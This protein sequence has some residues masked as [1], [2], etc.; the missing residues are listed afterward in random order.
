MLTNNLRLL[1]ANNNIDTISELVE[2]SGLSR[3]AVNKI[4]RDENI[5]NMSLAT[6]I[7]LCDA[8]KCSL[9]MLVEYVPEGVAVNEQQGQYKVDISDEI[10]NLR[11]QI[12][13]MKLMINSMSNEIIYISKNQ[14]QQPRAQTDLFTD[15]Y[16]K[17][18][19]RFNLERSD[20]T[21]KDSSN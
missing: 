20:Q 9:S 21:K 7:S 16:N 1:M 11:D 2:I 6:L 4:F 19:D 10:Q 13:N 15:Y 17:T 5:E 18:V 14:S 8:L 12:A 3:N